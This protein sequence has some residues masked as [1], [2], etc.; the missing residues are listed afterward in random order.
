M[1][2]SSQEKQLAAAFKKINQPLDNDGELISKGMMMCAMFKLSANELVDKWEAYLVN[3]GLSDT[4]PSSTHFDALKS[5]LQRSKSRF[6]ATNSN[7][8]A[9][10]TNNTNS[11]LYN[12]DTLHLF[13]EGLN[14]AAAQPSKKMEIDK[15]NVG[16]SPKARSSSTSPPSSLELDVDI[17]NSDATTPMTSLTRPASL[18]STTTTTTNNHFKNRTNSGK[19]ELEFDSS[20]LKN[21]NNSKLSDMMDV[22]VDENSDAMDIN[23]VDE[24]VSVSILP[25]GCTRKYRCMSN[26]LQERAEAYE[27]RKLR[28]ARLIAK[29]LRD[30]E[31][32]DSSNLIDSARA[33]GVSLEQFKQDMGL[34]TEDND[35]FLTGALFALEESSTNT[36]SSGAQGGQSHKLSP[37]SLVLSPADL[38]SISEGLEMEEEGEEDPLENVSIASLLAAGTRVPVFPS[39]SLSSY[40]FFPGQ[41]VGAL[42][43]NPTGRRFI[44]SKLVSAKIQKTVGEH[45]TRA[46]M[47]IAS[48][49]FMTADSNLCSR[50]SREPLRALLS[51]A[52]AA[53]TQILF[54]VGPFVDKN[55]RL[56]ETGMLVDY[57][58]DELFQLM[59]TEIVDEL[60]TKNGSKMKVV[61]VPSLRDIH[62]IPV[63]PQPPFTLPTA[64]A[65]NSRVISASN[66]ATLK[67][68]NGVLVGVTSTDVL[69]HLSAFEISKGATDDRISRLCRHIIEQRSYYPLNPPAQGVNIDA[70]HLKEIEFVKDS[71][72]PNIL[73]LPSDLPHFVK[74]VDGVLCVNPGRVIKGNAGGTFA[75]IE[76]RP[77]TKGNND[78]QAK[79]CIVAV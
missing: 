59:V 8:V 2:L 33:L 23:D 40:S 71:N 17:N 70:P 10:A 49:P 32:I 15:E 77:S 11:G 41:I 54:L 24:N 20:S 45:T 3:H 60:Q 13:E 44:I 53:N 21:N 63:M 19:I 67:I 4:S 66:P 48:G 55:N 25:G 29:R 78:L 47:T 58:F 72:I 79:A 46:K 38:S 34:N 42:G 35:T 39:F 52:I 69:R 64:I 62:H 26:K 56:I 31:D 14:K 50:E 22:D 5:E 30:E 28:V 61:F 6:K 9:S 43:S 36:M 1:L 57:T 75:T 65:S 74:M 51:H 68:G 27:E 73:L 16:Q 76:V 7:N 12:K 18:A 37:T